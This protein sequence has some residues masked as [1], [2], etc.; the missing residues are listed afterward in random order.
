[1]EPPK[2]YTEKKKHSKAQNITKPHHKMR[3]NRLRAYNEKMEWGVT[4]AQV[5]MD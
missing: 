3:K 4:Q 5:E 2:N 1:M